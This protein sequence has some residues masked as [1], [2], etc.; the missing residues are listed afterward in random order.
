MHHHK[1]ELI[2]VFCLLAVVDDVFQALRGVK[3][4]DH[5]KYHEFQD[6]IVTTIKDLL[7]LGMVCM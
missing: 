3:Q 5:A 4:Y 6:E 7:D 2:I 1:F